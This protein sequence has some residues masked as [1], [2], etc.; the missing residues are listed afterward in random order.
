M[1]L[2]P[3]PF[4]QANTITTGFFVVNWRPIHC[5]YSSLSES[6]FIVWFNPGNSQHHWCQMYSSH[7]NMRHFTFLILKPNMRFLL[8][9]QV[10]VCAYTYNRLLLDI[11]QN[12]RV[13]AVC[14]HVEKSLSLYSASFLLMSFRFAW[15]ITQLS[16]AS[17]VYDYLAVWCSSDESLVCITS[18]VVGVACMGQWFWIIHR[19]SIGVRWLV[20]LILYLRCVMITRFP[21][22]LRDC[23]VRCL[24]AHRF[25]LL[26]SL[27]FSLENSPSHTD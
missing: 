2:A 12:K 26:N 14:I 4:K 9:S 24:W 7:S 6:C 3:S 22:V 8:H 5:I 25:P 17:F 18:I 21:Y 19:M 1:Q 16:Y 11:L 15:I 13:V 10:I 23:L 27:N 20:S